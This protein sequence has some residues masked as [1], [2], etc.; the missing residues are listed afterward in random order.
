MTNQ[1]ATTILQ[2]LG[3]NRFAAMTGAKGF[4]GSDDALMFKLPGTKTYGNGITAV[5]VVLT[6]ADDYS[7]TFYQGRKFAVSA[8]R[9]GVYADSL[10]AVFEIETGLRTSL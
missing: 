7:V 2:Q 8:T 4:I 10:R 1:V 9:E 5:R 3:G 6:A